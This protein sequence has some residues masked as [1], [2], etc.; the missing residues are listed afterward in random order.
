M[1]RTVSLLF[2]A[3]FVVAPSAAQSAAAQETEPIRILMIGDS[4]MADYPKPPADRPDLTGWGQVFAERFTDRVVVIN[5]ARSG[6]SSKSFLAEGLWDDALKTKADYVFI[7][8]GHNDQP[9]KDDRTT[10][11]DGDYRDNLKRYLDDARRN[12]GSARFS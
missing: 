2:L 8:F 11:P 9:G 3:A 10:D 4:T 7:Q 5:K 6:R 12:K 1:M